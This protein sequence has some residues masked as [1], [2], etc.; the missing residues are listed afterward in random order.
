MSALIDLVGE[1]TGANLGGVRRILDGVAAG[2]NVVAGLYH[3]I[4]NGL[5]W[6]FEGGFEKAASFTL[7]VLENFNWFGVIL[8]VATLFIHI[9]LDSGRDVLPPSDDGGD[10]CGNV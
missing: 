5:G 6:L 3:A 8:L 4:E 1:W 10:R 9:D 2:I 7:N